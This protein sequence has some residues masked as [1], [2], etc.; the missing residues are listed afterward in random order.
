MRFTEKIQEEAINSA[1]KQPI[2]IGSKVLAARCTMR[3]G[4]D[5]Q[6]LKKIS[7]ITRIDNN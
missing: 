3:D 1:K 5:E 4:W 7:G 2:I 6:Y